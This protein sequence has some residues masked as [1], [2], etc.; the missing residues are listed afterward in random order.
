MP[1][2]IDEA[3]ENPDNVRAGTSEEGPTTVYEKDNVGVVVNED[4]VI[5]TVWKN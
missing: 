2:D 3:M 4:G 1:Q 5:V